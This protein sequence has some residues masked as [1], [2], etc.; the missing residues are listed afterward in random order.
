M[1]I[2]NWEKNLSFVTSSSELHSKIVLEN[3]QNS[4]T[5]SL[6]GANSTT[7]NNVFS[8]WA[9]QPSFPDPKIQIPDKKS[10]SLS[11]NDEI[12]SPSSPEAGKPSLIKED[13]LMGSINENYFESNK[14]SPTDSNSQTPEKDSKLVKTTMTQEI[15]KE[16]ELKA[17][18]L[19][20]LVN[21]PSSNTPNSKNLK[22]FKKKKFDKTKPQNGFKLFEFGKLILGFGGK[23]SRSESRI[24]TLD[25]E[26]WTVCC[27]L[28]AIFFF[29]FFL[30][31]CF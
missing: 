11:K 1:D 20:N 8:C 10:F 2:K 22:A 28:F 7:N 3:V 19:Y 5:Q 24:E 25:V 16:D 21:S 27:F 31:S 6:P 18:E 29:I 12:T 4:K 13:T 26:N 15:T 23:S 30:I 17:Q 9:M 14:N